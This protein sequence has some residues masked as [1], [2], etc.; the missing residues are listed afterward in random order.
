MCG[1][2]LGPQVVFLMIVGVLAWAHLT[3]TVPVVQ[4]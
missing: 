3:F 2:D 1:N 4:E